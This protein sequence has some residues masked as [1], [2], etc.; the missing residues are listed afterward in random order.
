MALDTFHTY[1]ELYEEFFEASFKRVP[2]HNLI[3]EYALIEGA[4]RIERNATAW[5]FYTP[6]SLSEW[7]LFTLLDVRRAARVAARRCPRQAAH[8]PL[9]RRPAARVPR[10]RRRALPPDTCLSVSFWMPA[11]R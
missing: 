11:S 6:E 2:K 5:Y 9:P 1:K 4:V 7:E 10:A 3:A 8:A